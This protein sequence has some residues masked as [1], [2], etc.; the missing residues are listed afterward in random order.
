MAP[1]SIFLCC[2]RPGIGDGDTLP[3]QEVPDRGQIEDGVVKA[4]RNPVHVQEDLLTSVS[5][6]GVCGSPVSPCPRPARALRRVRPPPDVHQMAPCRADDTTRTCLAQRRK[7]AKKKRSALGAS[8]NALSGEAPRLSRS[9]QR[10]SPVVAAICAGE[11]HACASR[12]EAAPTG[13]LSELR[14]GAK[15]PSFFLCVSATLR[16]LLLIVLLH[17]PFLA[18]SQG[19][20]TS[21]RGRT[22]IELTNPIPAKLLADRLVERYRNPEAVRCR[23]RCRNRSRYRACG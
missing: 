21:C 4:G 23:C 19:V 9:S 13:W 20:L 2:P 6:P 14:H 5:E 7:G 8:S 15:S 18:S 22:R 12:P 3:A 16:E 17:E 10:Q 11:T 1:G